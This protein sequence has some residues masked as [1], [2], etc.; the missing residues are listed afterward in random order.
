MY[1]QGKRIPDSNTLEKL[2]DFFN[3]SID[4]LLGRTHI[5]KVDLQKPL[6]NNVNSAK[7]IEMI[8]FILTGQDRHEYFE[9]LLMSEKREFLSFLLYDIETLTVTR[10]T[11]SKIIENKKAL[12][13]MLLMGDI[14][15]NNNNENR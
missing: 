3:V 8:D 4:F 10:D 7:L 2:S 9:A 11:F 6:D 1:E 15:N 14:L 12:D 13:K 5:I